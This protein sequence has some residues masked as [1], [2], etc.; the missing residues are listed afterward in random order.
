MPG[1]HNCCSTG[2]LTAALLASFLGLPVTYPFRHHS[3]SAWSCNTPNSSSNF[4]HLA[5][6]RLLTLAQFSL[7]LVQCQR[8]LQDTVKV[9]VDGF[10]QMKSPWAG[11]SSLTGA[12]S[13]SHSFHDCSQVQTIHCHLWLTVAAMF[14]NK[15][16]VC[17]AMVG[18][19]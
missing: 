15:L 4:G 5:I 12:K 2:L 18:G 13:V 7:L 1:G 6:P 8:C 14:G 3:T 17:R 9:A 10:S 19:S 11:K 16:C